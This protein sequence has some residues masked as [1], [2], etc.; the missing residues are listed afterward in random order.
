MK[1]TLTLAEL[2][3]MY[4]C[5]PA[6]DVFV[7]TFGFQASIGDI[8]QR[9]H[10]IDATDWEAWLL[11]RNVELTKS[12]LKH[13]ADVHA[14][15]EWALYLA[16]AG[17]RLDVVKL[18]LKH[19]ADVHAEDDEALRYAGENGHLDVVKLLLK[20]GADVHAVSEGGMRD[21]RDMGYEKIVRLLEKHMVKAKAK[22]KRA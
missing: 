17:G 12:L 21:M 22:A 19:G 18:L 5:E 10:A 15:N 1:Q 8:V 13:G 16:A 2:K 7:K 3:K 9:L 4:A 14:A 20:N 6:R 11:A